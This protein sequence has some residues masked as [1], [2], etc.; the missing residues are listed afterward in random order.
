LPSSPEYIHNL[1]LFGK[2]VQKPYRP[3]R[4]TFAKLQG[5]LQRNQLQQA[6][7]VPKGQFNR[8]DLLLRAS[9][10]IGNGAVPN[11]TFLSVRFSEEMT[12]IGFSF[13]VKG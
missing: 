12:G 4:G 6:F 7:F 5:F 9:G 11:F 10:E 13:L 1:K 2:A 3:N 8:F